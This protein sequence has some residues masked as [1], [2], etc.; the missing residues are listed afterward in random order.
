MKDL[1]QKKLESYSC[2]NSD[3]EENAIKEIT[4]EV[5]LYALFKTG[6]FEK[7]SFQ[8]GTCLR[9]LYGL[10]RF[11]EDLD[12]VLDQPD[13]DFSIQSYLDQV[14]PIMSVYGYNIEVTGKDRAHSTVKTRFL[15][16]DSLIKMF[17]FQHYSAPSK[18]IKIKIEIDVHP[19]LN[20]KSEI[21]Y[22]DFPIDF[23]VRAHDPSS[24]FAGKL[25]AL[26]CRPYTKGRDWYDLTWYVARKTPVNLALLSSA[27]HQMGPFKE[28]SPS[29]DLDWVKKH[30][31]T[32]IDDTDWTQAKEDVRRFVRPEKLETLDLWSKDFFMSKVDKLF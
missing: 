29:I 18:K 6:F 9:I 28:Q 21:K 14:V 3:D 27:L 32:K 1:I 4:Q 25:H 11:S 16:D 24:L 10:D 19:P 7:A 20:A 12:F 31:T 13:S 2:K 17:S 5:A 22:C 23:A 26:L 30:L 8:G 15:K